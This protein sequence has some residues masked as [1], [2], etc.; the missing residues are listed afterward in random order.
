MGN[1]EAGSALHEVIHCLLNLD[2]GSG[3]DGGGRLVQNHDPIVCQNCT[4]NGEQ[5]FLSLG[6][7]AGIFV[8][9]HL[10]A[11]RQ[12]ADKAVRMGCLC[13]SNDFF[14]RCIQS[15]IADIFHNRALEQPSV[16]QDH[17][18]R[19]PQVV[20]FKVFDVVPV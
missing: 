2:F 15:A 5:L 1:D 6:N 11:V 12:L 14:I 10:V 8:Q 13:S 7:I 19:F 3:I 20:P 16:L 9:F 18:E 4:G 17:A